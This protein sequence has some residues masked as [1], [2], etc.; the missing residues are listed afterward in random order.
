M[1]D[2]IDYATIA[3]ARD[4]AEGIGR[5]VGRVNTAALAAIEPLQAW[6]DSAGFGYRLRRIGTRRTKTP[7]TAR[8]LELAPGVESLPT[9][10]AFEATC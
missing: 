7:A 4:L 3:A 2:P 8:N 9:N 6:R 5:C 10:L 1:T